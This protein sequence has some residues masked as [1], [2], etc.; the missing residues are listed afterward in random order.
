MRRDASAGA[1]QV[2]V[3]SPPELRTLRGSR[4]HTYPGSSFTSGQQDP[5]RP[6]PLE[7]IQ[8]GTQRAVAP[9]EDPEAGVDLLP[10]SLLHR[11]SPSEYPTRRRS[12]L[13]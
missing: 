13:T 12:V 9:A 6:P 7:M 8:G 2:C 11:R 3:F 5:E 1:E 10:I 4:A